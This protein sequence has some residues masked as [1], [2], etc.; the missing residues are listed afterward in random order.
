MIE[1][2]DTTTLEDNLTIS[3]KTEQYIHYSPVIDFL[4]I[5]P[6]DTVTH[7]YKDVTI[8]V[9]IIVKEIGGKKPKCPLLEE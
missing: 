6:K 1:F 8:A 2:V 9:L 7:T 5:N 4:P 3:C